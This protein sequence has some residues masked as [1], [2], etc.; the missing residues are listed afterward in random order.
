MFRKLR[1]NKGFNL[2][3]MLIVIGVVV[4][5]FA[6]AFI[7]VWNH[8]R[9]LKQLEF[10][11][12]AKEIFVAAQNHLTAA[13]GQ[14]YL[15]RTGTGDQ[16]AAAAGEP[17]VYYFIIGGTGSDYTSPTDESS[18]LNLMLPFG[19]IDETV[20]GGGSYIIRYQTEP[21]QVLDVF[22]S[23]KDGVRYG[24]TYLKSEYD[25]LINNY[26][27]VD[28]A[29]NVVSKKAERRNYGGAILGYYGG[30]D[31]IN[32]ASVT[33]K[34]PTFEIHNEERLYV[35]VSNPNDYSSA[36]WASSDKIRIKLIV[37]GK[38]S[39]NMKEI[40]LIDGSGVLHYC[41]D[42]YGDNFKVVFDDVTA[43]K[44][45]FCYQF[46]STE[47]FSGTGD[48]IP[49]EDIEVKVVAFSNDKLS[50]IAESSVKTTNSLFSDDTVVD[51]TDGTKNVADIKNMRHLENL[52]RA[53]SGLTEDNSSGVYFPKATQSKDLSW[54]EFREAIDGSDPDAVQVFYFN[55]MLRSVSFTQDQTGTGGGLFLPVDP[56]RSINYDGQGHRISEV[57]VNISGN[58]GLFGSLVNGKVENIELVDFDV[59]STGGPAGALAA[60][61]NDATKVSYV[62]AHNTTTADDSG[63]MV[64]G[65]GSAGGLI[66]E[67]K[68]T[69]VEASAAALYVLSDT[70][71]A[72]GLIGKTVGGE[73]T[74]SY[75]G[76]HTENGTYKDTDTGKARINVIGA[77]SAGGLVGETEG[78]SIAYSYSTCSVS[79][80]TAGGLI[81]SVGTWTDSGSVE[82]D[83]SVAGSYSTGTV[84]GY[85]ANQGGSLIGTL[86]VTD[87]SVIGTK[88]K[89]NSFFGAVTNDLRAVGSDES[90]TYSA[91]VALPFDVSVESYN[92]FSFKDNYRAS[93]DAP[94]AFAYDE[95]LVYEFGGKTDMPTLDRVLTRLG[96]TVDL[97]GWP[98]YMKN[99]TG[100]SAKHWGDWPSP[101]TKVIN[102]H[103]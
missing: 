9:S 63:Y 97:S 58:A 73:I 50:N 42:M 77:T 23:P 48:L 74:S 51:L 45:K 46:C 37:I 38:T 87:P 1:S 44:S 36:G 15:G 52:S 5:L 24:H 13:D 11:G 72:G 86:S 85:S 81:G 29:G 60:L 35:T 62:L 16:E 41:E 76:G 26:R 18:L 98:D 64:R 57:K 75:A 59:R 82:H 49:G 84:A 2:A 90:G 43:A 27:D 14:G 54:T 8:Q 67:T 25:S 68:G 53:V 22:Y 17:K 7:A 6:V 83:T 78:T 70:G 103:E 69:T 61:A 79:G 100:T 28:P 80:V 96:Q 4:A 12:I 21:A 20:R 32:K 19:A 66:G 89:D 93:D 65:Y 99:E 92:R 91:T 3:E 101:E 55:T 71:A 30:V 34:K 31:P 10:D 88:Y 56:P 39:G 94:N 47:G 102:E 95:Y 33:I 40:P